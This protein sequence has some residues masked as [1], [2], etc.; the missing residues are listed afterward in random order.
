MR[1]EK[2]LGDVLYALNAWITLSYA[3]T[4]A[5]HYLMYQYMYKLFKSQ[6]GEL[7]VGLLQASRAA[8]CACE[9][10]YS[11]QDRGFEA[12]LEFSH[13]HSV[14]FS[15]NQTQLEKMRCDV[16]PSQESNW[17][18]RGWAPRKKKR[19]SSILSAP[20]HLFPSLLL[21]SSFSP[22]IPVL[23]INW[24]RDRGEAQ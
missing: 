21:L 12:V 17:L 15:R 5:S 9:W 10:K 22:H 23:L 16:T 1:S 6:P 8:F 13:Q 2:H 18:F 19:R 4:L 24:C 11:N 14:A 7:A 20:A 3:S